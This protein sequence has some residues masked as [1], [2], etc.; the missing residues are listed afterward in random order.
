VVTTTTGGLIEALQLDF[1][2]DIFYFLKIMKN[3]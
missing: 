2:A 3:G 1:M